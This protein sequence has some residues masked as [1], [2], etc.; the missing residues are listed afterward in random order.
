MSR[1]HKILIGSTLLPMLIMLIGWVINDYYP[2][3]NK[4]LMA[5]DFS[6][7]FIDLY[8]S[9]KGRSYQA[10]LPLS[11]ILSQNP[12]GKYGRQLGLLSFQSF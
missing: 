7:Q 11:F 1:K 2:F 5:I 12:L 10:T 4:S 9:Q 3:G 8:V 6:Q